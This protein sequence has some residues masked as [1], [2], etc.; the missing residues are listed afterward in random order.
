MRDTSNVFHLAIPCKDLDAAFDFY[1]TKLGC[2]LARRYPDRITL[3]FFGDQLVCHLSSKIDPEPQ[4]YPRHFGVTFRDKWEFDN[5]LALARTRELP[6][7][8]EPSV[9]FKGRAEE[10]LMFFLIDPSNN[11]LEFKYYRDPRM[12]Y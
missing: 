3:D 4:M 12:M 6:F 10:H 9:R 2:K 11:L 8:E 1:V 7:F 5:L